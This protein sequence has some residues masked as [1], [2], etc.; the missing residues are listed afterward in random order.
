VKIAHDDLKCVY[1]KDECGY[2]ADNGVC[3]VF[4]GGMEICPYDKLEEKDAQGEKGN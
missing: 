2:M 4:E 3:L 1:Q